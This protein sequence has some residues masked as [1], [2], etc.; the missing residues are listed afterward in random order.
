MATDTGK[1][2]AFFSTSLMQHG[3]R[4]Q[5]SAGTV[6]AAIAFGGRACLS[7]CMLHEL[8]GLSFFQ[9]FFWGHRVFPSCFM[10]ERI[11]LP[12]L[13]CELQSLVGTAG[14][15]AGSDLSDYCWTSTASV[16]DPDEP[17]GER[18]RSDT[19][20]VLQLRAKD[21]T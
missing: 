8:S 12:D 5:S 7:V 13:N 11:G 17:Q 15:T 20:G 19:G 4:E 14:P 18:Q 3:I 21:V 1:F 9:D 16:S 10:I 2:V 6:F